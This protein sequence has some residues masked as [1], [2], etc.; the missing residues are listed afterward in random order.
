MKKDIH[1]KYFPAAT[2]TCVCGE[3]FVAGATVEKIEVERCSNCH[4]FYTGQEKTLDTAGR[5]DRFKK[6]Q[7]KAAG[8]ASARAKKPKLAAVSTEEAAAGSETAEDSK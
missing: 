2:I 1:P 4:P 7:E 8:A 6:R 5:V 3:S